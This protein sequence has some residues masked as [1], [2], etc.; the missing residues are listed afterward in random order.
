MNK[1]PKITLLFFTLVFLFSCR[2]Y[3]YQAI[4]ETMAKAN[5][6]EK[7][8]II[9]AEFVDSKEVLEV[10]VKEKFGGEEVKIGAVGIAKYNEEKDC[11]E[12]GKC[13]L[14]TAILNPNSFH[15]M[16]DLDDLEK[17]KTI[18]LEIARET[19][20]GISNLENYNIIEIGFILSDENNWAQVKK[21]NSVYFSLPDLATSSFNNVLLRQ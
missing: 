4:M 6:L 2:S 3:D 1:I 18:G 8:Y 14:K 19:I 20:K 12:N 13:W 15:N 17:I 9:N 11:F 21:T 16:D 10:C 7:T 5:K